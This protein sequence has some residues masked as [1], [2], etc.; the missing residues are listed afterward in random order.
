M[1]RGSWT[2]KILSIGVAVAGCCM[3]APLPPAEAECLS[4]SC[5]ARTMGPDGS[6]LMLM[7]WLAIMAVVYLVV[8]RLE[9]MSTGPCSFW[10]RIL[11]QKRCPNE[12]VHP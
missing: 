2:D 5:L 3:A 7:L 1:I 6:L 4:P 12:K 9:R 8:K 11:N 10:L